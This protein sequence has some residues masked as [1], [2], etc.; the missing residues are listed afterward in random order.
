MKTRLL[1]LMALALGLAA[2]AIAQSSSPVLIN[3][4]TEI[5]V[6]D[7]MVGSI[8]VTAGGTGYTVPPDVT[9]TGGGGFGATA[10]ATIDSGGAVTAVNVTNPGNGYLIAPTVSFSGGG[11]GSPGPQG[12]MAT[13]YLNDAE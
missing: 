1:S 13:A 6:T 12:A 2:P 4:I 9:L 10:T 3:A 7:G 5:D 8:T 11:T